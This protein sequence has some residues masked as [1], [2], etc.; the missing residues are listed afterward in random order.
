MFQD[1][2]R[3]FLG[4][5]KQPARDFF[6]GSQKLVSPVP[7]KPQPTFGQQLMR[8]ANDAF[9]SFGNSPIG[10]GIVSAQNFIESPRPNRVIPQ[11]QPFSPNTM[12]GTVGNTVANIPG[13][14]AN[15]VVGQ[16]ILD[17]ASD[18][19]R[20]IG[21]TISG[22]QLPSYESMKSPAGR[23]GYQLGNIFNPQAGAVT[24]Q[25]PKQYVGN[26]AGAVEP[27]FTAY[28]GAN[29]FNMGKQSLQEAGKNTFKYAVKR[30]ALQGGFLG[31][32]GGGISALSQGRDIKNDNEY[33]KNLAMNV[34]AGVGIGATLGAGVEGGGSALGVVRN[35]LLS[36]VK[37]KLPDGT[38]AAHVVNQFIR[39]E[40]G[41]FAGK[42]HVGKE[43]VFY[44]DLRESL[45]LPR[46]GDYRGGF[47]DFTG[48]KP[49][50]KTDPLTGKT[51]YN[52][53]AVATD[54]TYNVEQG[55]LSDLKVFQGMD[56]ASK[57]KF[58]PIMRQKYP[59]DAGF[60][61]GSA[62]TKQ[63][64][65][66]HPDLRTK[67]VPGSYTN[68]TNVDNR[69][70]PQSVQPKT[71]S[72]WKKSRFSNGGGYAD[73]PVIRREDN[74]TLYQGG[75][76]ENRQ[77]WTPDEKYASQFGKVTKKT[78]SFYK[79]DNGNR[80]TDVYVEAKN[81]PQS[82]DPLTPGSVT[83]R[84]DLLNQ[85]TQLEQKG[86]E[87]LAI[88]QTQAEAARAIR[89]S[90]SPEVIANINKVKQMAKSQS[91]LE[92]DIETLRKRNPKL[93]ES[94]VESV[95][96]NHSN[97]GLSDE[98]ALRMALD[99]PSGADLRVKKPPEL[100][101]AQE[102]RQQANQVQDMVYN[103]QAS[104]ETKQKIIEQNQNLLKENAKRE[105][106]EWQRFVRN[107][108]IAATPGNQAQG[109]GNMFRKATMS[110]ASRNIEQLNDISGFSAGNRDLT[111]NFKAVYGK[112]FDQVK[113]AVL[114]PFDRAK[115]Q[116]VDDL[117]TW[118][119]SLDT[120]IIKRF[121]IG[122]GSKESAAIQNYGEGKM[123]LDE[124]KKMFPT[125]WQGIVESDQW[126]RK[127]YD[128][129]LDQVNQSR[130][131]IYGNNPEKIVPKRSD[132][133]RH[134]KEMAQG[135]R[136]LMNIF[137][138]PANISSNLSG[139]SEFTKPKSKYASFMQKR[140]GVM[141][142]EDA[143]GGFLDYIKA[144]SYAKNID[145]QTATFRNLAEELAGQT[146]E[147]TP[148]AARI[149]NF[150]EYLQDF[151]NDLAGKTNPLDRS[152]QKWIPGGRKTFQVISWLNSRVKANAV[153][154]N[155]S[156]AISQIFN[157]PQGIASANP[158]NASK[159]MGRSLASMFI[160]NKPM[161]QSIFIRERYSSN[162]FNK[163]ETGMVANVGK[164]AKWM[165]GALD[166]VGTKFIWNS[167]YEKALSE[168]IQN[169]AKYADDITRSLVAGR[170]IGEVP[171]LQKAKMTQLI[172]PFQLE[173]GNLW[174]VMKDFV[175]E[176]A[177]G[178]LA[179]LLVANYVF[180]RGAEKIRGSDV[181]FDPIQAT[182]E[183]IQTFEKEEDKKLG[184][185]KAGGRLAGEFASNIPGGQT[186][187]SLYPEYGAKI[188][189]IELPK[190]EEF[191]GKG[192]PTRFSSGLLAAEGLKDP[193]YKVIP[194]FGGSQLKKT[195]EGK[196]N[197]DKGYS[198]SK[199][200]RVQFQVDKNPVNEAKSYLFGKY[201]TP[202]ARQY[203]DEKKT[204][205][206]DV[207]SETYKMLPQDQKDTFY[208][209]IQ[210][211]RRVNA[212]IKQAE[213][214]IENGDDPS[215]IISQVSAAEDA[216]NTSEYA[217]KVLA[218]AQDKLAKKKLEFSGK[219][220]LEENGKIYY[221]NENGNPA[222]IDPSF[223]PTVPSLTGDKVYDK[224]IISKYQGDITEKQNDILQMKE[225]GKLS[226]DQAKVQLN[227][228]EEMR[229]SI[230]GTGSGRKKIKGL[231][232][233]KNFKIKT[234]SKKTINFKPSKPVSLKLP[235]LRSGLGRFKLK[236]FN[237]KK[238]SRS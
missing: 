2:I 48:G 178:K 44:G 1:K 151:S 157:V 57:A 9:I 85:A 138:T 193:L 121:K 196:K 174:W 141:T 118:S 110:P 36:V 208:K 222:I 49:A 95:R 120:D 72:V 168:G 66:L 17:P 59:N 229:K 143:V 101:E 106:D 137:D 220:Y 160:E 124:V 170:G 114:D 173:V 234:S 71:V 6:G 21:N 24:P 169:P 226:L 98:Q 7:Q 163:F 87:Q 192:D 200:G 113:H 207:Q 23:F 221:L 31:G 233:F 132:Y 195:I 5:L 62:D 53:P 63:A 145:P 46:T 176:K 224:K 75:H 165:T 216:P 116:Y 65:I 88:N 43:P 148:N 172:A 67:A 191:F 91:F 166:E 202:E 103:A 198:E 33:Y 28:G 209:S 212:L 146:T 215:G 115:G 187:A 74:I 142:E 99:L 164:F 223:S 126:F 32:V 218:K 109:V 50:I 82:T 29:L 130:R 133:Y 93:V 167:H 205:L 147:G 39:D 179:T 56:E 22:R 69:L 51:T 230:K 10:K 177:F 102:L 34:F 181:V 41:R 92:G 188:G 61:Q 73:V 136:G 86:S 70:I 112:R 76:G 128:T 4:T 40:M 149:N 203:F 107:Q 83:P 197:Y 235:Q 194:P 84:T 20:V 27:A 122:K 153:I 225:I 210:E 171:L 80:V 182:I 79:I 127:Q 90:Y 19:G 26:V 81:K 131:R 78:G 155:V 183:A 8:G 52:S 89:G 42:K 217:K 64:D 18:V 232:A 12:R 123:S 238:V 77:F 158:V 214:A 15:T 189:D 139:V 16:G 184:L 117:K 104:P 236:S 154:G 94:V 227:K 60:I 201:S 237:P 152:A 185:F 96:E 100:M 144:A 3:N 35:K 134:F 45:G 55:R 125:K 156:S 119:D 150:I 206:G 38:N 13:M 68:V 54:G 199:T 213:E 11:I 190:R 159:G 97:G 108:T 135:F 186:A 25:T 211:E 30:G 105:F 47:V 162:I 37:G 111:R 231:S 219:D 228:L 14:I 204:P 58:G 180:N 129:M 161:N 175:D 140:L